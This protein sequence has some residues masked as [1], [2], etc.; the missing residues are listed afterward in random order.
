MRL[1]ERTLRKNWVIYIFSRYIYNL[2]F[3]KFFFEP[4]CE[5]FDFLINKKKLIII[6]VGSSDGSFTKNLSKKLYNSIFFCFEPL[7]FLHKRFKP[8][9]QNK[10]KTYRYACSSKSGLTKVYT[11]YRIFFGFKLYLKF[12]SSINKNFIKKNIQQYLNKDDLF[13]R[14]ISTLVKLRKLDEFKLKPSILK[15][16]VEGYEDDVLKG[17]TRTILKYLP[18]IIV[19]NPTTYFDNTLR[20]LGYIKYQYNS[21]LK[22]LS[23]IIKNNKNSYNYI[24]INKNKKKL[25]SKNIF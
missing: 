7:D 3:V 19:E 5:I 16:D 13:F 18:L 23:P 14:Y 6:D 22:K 17:A 8:Y 20:D 21:K 25:L 9:N 1:I 11:P 24:F 4:E 12:F 15:I 10:I 2:L